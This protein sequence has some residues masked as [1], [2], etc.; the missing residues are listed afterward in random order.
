MKL[1]LFIIFWISGIVLAFL[2]D[3]ELREYKCYYH[4][5]IYLFTSILLTLFMSWGMVILLFI[6]DEF[7]LPKKLYHNCN[8]YF[9][10][11]YEEEYLDENGNPTEP[12]K[13]KI[14]HTYKVYYCEHCGKEIK[15][16]QLQ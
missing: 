15:R 10:M 11:S 2:G 8:K 3:R 13:C 9:R 12:S 4:P 1:L 7:E 14:H 16:E 6:N 5:K